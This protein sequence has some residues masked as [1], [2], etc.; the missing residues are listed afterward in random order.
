M[1]IVG[2]WN[3]RV[4]FGIAF[5]ALVCLSGCW[6]RV[7]IEER[8]VVLGIA[9]DAEDP[10]EAK[11]EPAVSHSSKE[12]RAPQTGMIR[13]MVQLAVPGRIPL[14]PGGSEGG[15]GGGAA[16]QQTVWALD[17][18]GHTMDDA[19]S[20]LQQQVSSPL[21]FGHLRVI[22]ISE[23]LAK[24]GLQNINDYLRR[25][26]EVRRTSWMVV[27]KGSAVELMKAAPELER[28]PTL[29]L[30]ATLDQA[31]RMGK[32]PLD[33]VGLFWTNSSKRGQEGYLPYVELM[34]NDNVLI[35]GLAFFKGHKMVDSTT[36]GEIGAYMA[37]KG[38]NPAGYQVFANIPGS[39]QEMVVYSVTH[40]KSKIKVS[41]KNGRPHFKLQIH[42]EGNLREKTDVNFPLNE[43]ML[44]DIE[45]D[46]EKNAKQAIGDFIKKTQEKGADIFGFGEY[47][48]AKKPGYWNRE[49]GNKTRWQDMYKE[50][51]FEVA[52]DYKIRR[53]G[54]KAR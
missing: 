43:S 32:L 51:T 31:V 24:R 52:V 26:S 22:V 33:F 34:E 8:A 12:F 13:L 21:F 17:V 36:P 46:I 50:A 35:S 16:Q 29:Y 3:H 40:R 11:N 27:S 5:L 7:E 39:E 20:N 10:S 47:V 6:D 18:V 45:R 37:I 28:V 9:V 53:I 30:T 19:V 25:N 1:T 38:I 15:G 44:R 49:I 4:K 2:N 23:K 14:G 54:M 48:R 41:I 42:V